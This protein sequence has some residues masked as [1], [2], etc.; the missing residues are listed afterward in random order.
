MLFGFFLLFFI[1]GCDSSSKKILSVTIGSEGGEV[2]SIDGLLKLV[3]PAG[4]LLDNTVISLERL[5]PEVEIEGEGLRR[6]YLAKPDGLIFTIPAILEAD[7]GEFID[8]PNLPII[9]STSESEGPELLSNQEVVTD[10]ENGTS[11][12]RGEV[13]HFS[14]FSIVRSTLILEINGV[15]FSSPANSPISS[16]EV[17]VGSTDPFGTHTTFDSVI[18]RDSSVAPIFINETN[19]LDIWDRAFITTDDGKAFVIPIAYRCGDPGT[20]VFI[21]DIT[22]TGNETTRVY[23]QIINGKTVTTLGPSDPFSTVTEIELISKPFQRTFHGSRLIKCIGDTETDTEVDIGDDTGTETDIGTSSASLESSQSEF[24]FEHIVGST[25]CP[26][27]VGTMTITNTG[28]TATDV[29][30]SSSTAALSTDVSSFTLGPNESRNVTIFFTCSQTTPFEGTI[31]FSGT[32]TST[33]VTVSG[34]IYY[35]L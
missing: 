24:S 3:I 6:F 29:S 30:S 27:N 21:A 13:N 15:P 28:D 2:H 34:D 9:I 18:Y 8:D 1:T 4:A 20:G 26:Q 32:G 11:I 23:T 14:T 5:S 16:I 35:E 17:V 10:F 25:G 7:V 22:V 19:P 31:T 33:Q 12:L